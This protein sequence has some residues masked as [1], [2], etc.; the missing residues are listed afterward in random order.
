MKQKRIMEIHKKEIKISRITKD[1][2]IYLVESLK[3]KQKT[4]N[5]L[6]KN[7]K[8]SNK[9]VKHNKMFYLNQIFKENL[10]VNSSLFAQIKAVNFFI[11]L[12][13]ALI[14]Q[15]VDLNKI[16]FLFMRLANL[17]NHVLELIVFMIIH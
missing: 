15:D 2:K 11:Q 6:L 7:R 12:K 13:N 5:N 1:K 16:V 17:D 9:M 14:F 10:S 4:T 3:V 8:N